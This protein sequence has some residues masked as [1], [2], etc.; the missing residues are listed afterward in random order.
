[1]PE[2][3]ASRFALEVFFLVALA[4]AL[5]LANQKPIVIAGVMAVSTLLPVI[6]RP[7]RASP[8][9]VAVPQKKFA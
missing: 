7:P 2:R 3:R 6:V 1:M 8:T 5:T 9:A 4:V